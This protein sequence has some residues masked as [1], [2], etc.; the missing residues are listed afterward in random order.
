MVRTLSEDPVD[1]GCLVI[2]ERSGGPPDAVLRVKL[3]S[4]SPWSESV[5]ELLLSQPGREFPVSVEAEARA[6]MT[7]DVMDGA[8]PV[9]RAAEV[10][11][12]KRVT[13]LPLPGARS[14]LEDPMSA[15]CTDQ[16]IVRVVGGFTE[17]ELDSETAVGMDNLTPSIG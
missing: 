7:N 12:Q 5:V 11:A 9:V 14:D 1:K 6:H 10:A 8:K 2:G 4:Q 3:G 17:G 13:A 16:L 15:H